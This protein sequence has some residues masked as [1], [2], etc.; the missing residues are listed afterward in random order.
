MPWFV[1]ENHIA[2]LSDSSN[3]RSAASGTTI[4]MG[5]LDL[6]QEYSLHERQQPS[7]SVV[8]LQRLL[9][10]SESY[11]KCSSSNSLDMLGNKLP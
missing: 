8:R 5:L 3:L 4:Q 9:S 6:R 2:I 7:H 11:G 1:L 10:L